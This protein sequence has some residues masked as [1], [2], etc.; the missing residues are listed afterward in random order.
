MVTGN[1]NPLRVKPIVAASFDAP[2]RKH[3]SGRLVIDAATREKDS[4][5][6]QRHLEPAD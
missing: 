2:A 5:A 3:V 1:M 4:N 6:Q